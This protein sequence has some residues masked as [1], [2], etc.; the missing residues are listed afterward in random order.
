MVRGLYKYYYSNNFK[1][2]PNSEN[3]YVSGK[4]KT[5]SVTQKDEPLGHCVS[6]FNSSPR[7]KKTKRKFKGKLSHTSSVSPNN[8][9]T[10]YYHSKVRCKWKSST[11]NYVLNDTFYKYLNLTSAWCFCH[12]IKKEISLINVCNTG[13]SIYFVIYMFRNVEYM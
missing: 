5:L 9:I 7:K 1:V 3:E 4:M 6:V 2:V 8:M 12:I 11:F 13:F 10:K